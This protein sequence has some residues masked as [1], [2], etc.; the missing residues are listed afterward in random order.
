MFK[1]KRLFF[2]LFWPIVLIFSL[3]FAFKIN[4]I[5]CKVS[6]N[7]C[8]QELY[9]KLE[10]LKGES[11]FFVNLDKELAN[12]EI[13]TETIL[14]KNYQ[15]QFPATISLEF[16]EE[17]V[18]YQQISEETIIFISEFGNILPSNQNINDLPQVS[19]NSS[20]SDESHEKIMKILKSVTG[21]NLRI[22]KVTRLSDKEIHINIKDNPK[23]IIDEEAIDSKVAILDTILNSR[24]IKE[25]GE[26]I[27]EID[28]R[29][30]LPVLR[31]TQ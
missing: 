10:I 23:I 22:E 8:S 3:I 13:S 18:A 27:R 16:T 21:S 30:N 5:H 4:I 2:L 28:L 24:E 19:W 15:K 29:F 17:K 6:E 9:Q 11:L 1:F 25:F 20:K 12:N 26:P 14:L 7:N 31:T